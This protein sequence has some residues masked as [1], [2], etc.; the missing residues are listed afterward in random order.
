MT[1][2]ESLPVK[3]TITAANE[4]RFQHAHLSEPLTA[5]SMGWKDPHNL[6]ALLDFLAPAVP[7]ARRFEFRK[8]T[9]ADFYYSE[10]DDVRAIGANFKRVGYSGET[11]QSKT[12]NKGLTIRVDHD[13]EVGPDWRERYV[14]LLVQRLLRNELRRAL[15][16]M[17][18]ATIASPQAWGA[19]ANPDGDL[20]A[21]LFQGTLGTGLRPNRILYGPVAWDLRQ[22]VYDQQDNAAA[23]R[24]GG[25]SPEELA[26]KVF[27][28]ELRLMSPYFHDGQELQAMV[29]HSI[30]LFYGQNGIHRDEPSTLKRFYTPTDDGNA[31]RVYVEEHAKYTDISVEHYSQVVLTNPDGLCR[32]TVSGA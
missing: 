13:E 15:K 22:N 12:L 26:R 2:I 31:F 1:A 7:V 23:A 32:M 5:Y 9:A 17:D 30:Y 16:A 14:G 10:D 29:E 8:S 24:A 28:D 19:N 11:V 20:R 4:S 21:E 25:L 27:V 6:Q 3:G 18:N